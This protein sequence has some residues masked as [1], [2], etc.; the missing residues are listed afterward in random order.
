MELVYKKSVEDLR[1]VLA[2]IQEL[3]TTLT[4]T[5][6][7]IQQIAD[8]C[9]V[10][11]SEPPYNGILEC[12]RKLARRDSQDLKH[13]VQLGREFCLY[14]YADRE[15][16]QNTLTNHCASRTD[17]GE[18]HEWTDAAIVIK[19]LLASRRS[20]QAVALEDGRQEGEAVG[21]EKALMGSRVIMLRVPF[22]E[23]E[24]TRQ[25]SIGEMIGILNGDPR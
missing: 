9:G 21:R 1:A 3:E 4:K 24:P 10:R 2:R 20:W 11:I 19:S 7:F 13:L 15:A 5:D 8:A 25:I 12:A 18:S 16:V 23:N 17:D 6:A 14:C 22:N